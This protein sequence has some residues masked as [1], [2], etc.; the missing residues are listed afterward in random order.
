MSVSSRVV[1]ITGAASGIGAAAARRLAGPGTTLI[2]HTRR[3]AVAL[4]EIAAGARATG[5]AAE[6]VLGDLAQDSAVD[7]LAEAVARHGR[8]DGLVACAGFANSA[9]F[10]TAT[11]AEL[12]AAHA[13]MPR[14]F[15]RLATAC[16]AQI[17]EA[18]GRV[19]AVSSFGAHRFR[20]AGHVF[21]VSGAAKAALEALA[22]S[23]AVQLA[24]SGATVNCVVPGY[25]RKDEGA[26]ASIDEEAF[27]RVVEAI[28]A[29]RL[30][31]P[32]E[33]AGAIAFLLSPEAA[34]ITGQSIHIDGGLT[35]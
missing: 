19:V 4:E 2:L 24:A 14:A 5:A 12:D 31:E 21:P 15:F 23:L 10:G 11:A 28:P 26:H 8:L 3:N 6:L 17:E 16:R 7:A 9:P 25:V 22:K 35:L 18:R 29:G 27:R 1:L 13:A 20:A 33:V 32:A 34:Y 30:A